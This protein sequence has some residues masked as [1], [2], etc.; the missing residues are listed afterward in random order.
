M[1]LVI[2]LLNLLNFPER[3]LNT[4]SGIITIL[5][6]ILFLYICWQLI[7]SISL[8]YV[9]SK[10]FHIKN[11]KWY[12]AFK[13]TNFF[14]AIGYF[15][16]GIA[17]H[18]SVSLFF[19]EVEKY[20]YNA[21]SKIVTIYFLICILILVN[22]I[23]SV[24]VIINKSNPNMPIKGIAQFI[25]IFVNFFGVLI[26]SAF[27]IGR[28]PTYFISALGI[29]TSVLMIVFKDPILGL[30]ASWQLASSKMLHIGDWIV[31]PKHNADGNVVDISLNTVTVQNWDNTI[32]AIPSYD[33]ISNSFQNW[34]GMVDSG[35]RRIKR[36][37]N[38]DMDTIDFLD[39][40]MT[41]KLKKFDLLKNYIEKK[42]A[43]LAQYNA[44]KNIKDNIH[45]GRSLT[46][47]GVFRIYCLEY[48]RSMSFINKNFTSMVRQLD[49]TP[50]GL[51]LEIYCF[52]NTTV[53]AD[54]ENYQSDIFD[55]LLAVMGDFNLEIFQNPSGRH[56]K[57]LP[58][59][60]QTP[61]KNN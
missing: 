3:Y 13:E 56:I 27:F 8:K 24:A 1:E 59:I 2:K 44:N 53:W 30:T 23:I 51:P 29:M 33:L 26:I 52:T 60:V 36:A 10:Y 38:I 15:G 55:H 34:R 7:R 40:K 47:I 45:N 11:P 31:S 41:A 21:A 17:A 61:N 39:D 14:A 28:E 32:I 46:N 4:A 58:I 19:P 12:A 16:A 43:E 22:K 50:S 20:Y 42:E 25:R 48:I 54:Y 6:F 18:L 35:G 5:F 57:H 9:Y 49:P 37:I